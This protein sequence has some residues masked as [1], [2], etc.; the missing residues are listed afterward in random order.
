[1]F[2][3]ILLN[4]D[5]DTQKFMIIKLVSNI[6]IR[7]SIEELFSTVR[8][9]SQA[10]FNKSAVNWEEC[11]PPYAVDQR[12][13]WNHTRGGNKGLPCDSDPSV[14]TVGECM[15]SFRAKKKFLSLSLALAR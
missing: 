5:H 8:I 2:I 12:A 10:T 11:T 1:L 9:V 7:R 3:N 4:V 15:T 13:F 14:R 6:D